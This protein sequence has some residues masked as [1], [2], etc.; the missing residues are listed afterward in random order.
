MIV[1]EEKNNLWF[2]SF[3]IGGWESDSAGVC[4]A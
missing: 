2:Y 3:R 1:K 4:V